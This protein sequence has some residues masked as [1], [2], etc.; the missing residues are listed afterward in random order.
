MDPREQRLAGHDRTGGGDQVR[1]GSTR[2]TLVN[3]NVTVE[4]HRTSI[5]LEPAMWEALAMVCK[6][7]NKSLNELVTGIARSRNQSTLTAGIRV[8]LL[9][10]FQAAATDEGHLRAGHGLARP[11]VRV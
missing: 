5:R 3:R 2:S 6:R 9:T 1:A 11:R 10:Y 7:E 4:G 8:F